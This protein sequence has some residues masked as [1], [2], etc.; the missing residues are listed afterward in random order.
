MRSKTSKSKRFRR[1]TREEIEH[2]TL[3]RCS[4]QDKEIIQ[5]W[6]E[7]LSK[8]QLARKSHNA[9]Q[10]FSLYRKDNL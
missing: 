5:K 2:T 8:K 9:I 6:K 3:K 1:I 7:G 4:M 10:G